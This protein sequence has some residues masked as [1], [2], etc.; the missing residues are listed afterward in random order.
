LGAA[1]IT[2]N[3]ER[4]HMPNIL[5]ATHDDN[6]ERIE[7]RTL[8]KRLAEIDL[9]EFDPRVLGRMNPMFSHSNFSELGDL[10]QT[11][12]K[13]ELYFLPQSELQ[14]IRRWAELALELF[15]RTKMA[16]IPP[17]Q[18]QE[19]NER[20]EV[21]YNECFSPISSAIAYWTTKKL[22]VKNQ[23]GEAEDSVKRIGEKETQVEN[24]VRAL[25]ERVQKAS[26]ADEAK[27]FRDEAKSH[28]KASYLWLGAAVGLGCVTL[29][30]AWN[31]YVTYDQFLR[32]MIDD[33][34]VAI[35]PAQSIQLGLAKL[36]FFSLL[37]GS[38]IWC[39]RIYRAHQHNYVLN[40]HRQN[41][42]STFDSFISSAQD[43]QTK[44][45]VLL[46]ATQAIFVMQ[47]T[48]YVSQEM[49]SGSVPQVVEI[50]KTVVQGSAKA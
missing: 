19:L 34:G 14:R 18:G 47:P 8:L 2:F 7:L 36:L 23:I 39:A 42:L 10:F 30:L 27:H 13:C 12:E 40:K 3:S 29:A 28:R 26:V 44:S 35:S 38:T 15:E 31:S 16:N 20:C 41:A 22:D 4:E 1:Y 11:L 37:V 21:L 48:G 5:V 25:Q 46:Q 9:D 45:A 6:R 32:R 49:E 33:N 50:V 17:T 43:A 24:M